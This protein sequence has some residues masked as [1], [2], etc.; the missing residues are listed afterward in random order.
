MK[1]SKKVEPTEEELAKIGQTNTEFLADGHPDPSKLEFWDFLGAIADK[2]LWDDYICYGYRV[3]PRRSDVQKPGYC[4]VY[5]NFFTIEDVRK[6][7]GGVK[8][9]L[10]LNRK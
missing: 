2:G 1:M 4:F 8:W 9:T 3:E 6:Q 10:K 7:Y 5:C